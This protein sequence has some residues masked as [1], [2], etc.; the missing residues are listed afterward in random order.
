P[1]RVGV[2]DGVADVEEAPEQL[3]QLQRASAG[4]VLYRVVAAEVLDGL[5]EALAPDESHGVIGASI[6]VCAQTIDRDDAWVLES[7]G[8]L[9]LEDKSLAAGRVVGML[10]EDLLERHL[11]MQLDIESG[12]DLAQSA[13]RMRPQ[14]A[15]SLAF[16]GD[17][18]DRQGRRA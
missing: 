16:A 5:L 2:M 17:C 14:Q 9:G 12:E 1:A 7:P 3:A 18:A 13:A 6:A 4:V 11:A 15:E 8:D 10:L